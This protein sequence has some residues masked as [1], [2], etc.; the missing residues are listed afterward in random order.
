MDESSERFR[1]PKTFDEDN[2]CVINSIPKS[3]VYM[4]KWALQVFREQKVRS[5]LLRLMLTKGKLLI[6]SVQCF[7]E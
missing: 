5:A 7:R 4:N 3:K 2:A 1:T 6:K